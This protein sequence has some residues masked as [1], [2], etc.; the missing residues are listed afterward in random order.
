MTS[1]EGGPA[2]GVVLELRRAP[3]YLRVVF[4][5][6]LM[7]DGAE[8]DALD[9][10]SDEPRDHERVVVYRRKAPAGTLHLD[11]SDKQGRRRGRWMTLA[12]YV[13]VEDQPD[14]ECVRDTTNWR[15]WCVER[16]A[17]ARTTA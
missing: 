7:G 2:A 3:L 12:E 10:L 4:R 8:F 11:Y 16:H 17:A 5:T 6:D 13:Y 1:F 9:L 15:A 14:A